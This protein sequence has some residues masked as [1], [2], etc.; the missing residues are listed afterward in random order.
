MIDLPP[1]SYEQT[2]V[3]IVRCGVSRANIRIKYADYLRSDEITIADLGTVANRKLS[4]LKASVHPFYVLTLANDA[5][6]AAYYR[7]SEREDRPKARAAARAWARARG[8][9]DS[10]PTFDPKFGI[11]KFAAALES[12]CGL[13]RGRALT[14]MGGAFLTVKSD[15]IYLKINKKTT[16]SLECITQMFAASNA[17]DKGISFGIIGN[18]AI[19]EEDKK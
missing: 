17:P 1:P 10:V 9:S 15:F 3:S 11:G 18:E 5:Q 7:Y 4:C 16:R 12:V 8:F 14:T 19:A 13:R 6:R 2:I